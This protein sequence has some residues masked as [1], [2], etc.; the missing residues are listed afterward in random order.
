ML[1]GRGVKRHHDPLEGVPDDERALVRI[2]LSPELLDWGAFPLWQGGDE[3]GEVLSGDEAIALLIVF[4]EGLLE[5]LFDLRDFV[6]LLHVVRCSEEERVVALRS[7]H[8]DG[9]SRAFKEGPHLLRPEA[10]RKTHGSRT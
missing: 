5:V 9:M 3:S 10:A 2:E 1:R 8:P 4:A 6:C 7:D